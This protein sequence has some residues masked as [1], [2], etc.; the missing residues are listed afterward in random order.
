MSA[1]KGKTWAGLPGSN[2]AAKGS[3]ERGLHDSRE[4]DAVARHARAP[5]LAC[6]EVVRAAKALDAAFADHEAPTDAWSLMAARKLAWDDHR[7]AVAALAKLE[8]T[9]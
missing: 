4:R 6:D 1:C 8:E 7:A 2:P 5:A 3:E 9:K